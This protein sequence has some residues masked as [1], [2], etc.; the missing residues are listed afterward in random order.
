MQDNMTEH[1]AAN[2]SSAINL[3]FIYHVLFRHKRSIIVFALLGFLAAGVVSYFKRPL[4]YSEAKL[5]VKYVMDARSVS[6]IGAD[7]QMKSPD[8]RGESI[9]NSEIEILNSRDLID[10]V[11]KLL[12]PGK[13]LAKLGGGNNPREAAIEIAKKLNVD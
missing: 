6:T 7:S 8:A 12:G 5:L 13:V 9:I 2:E 1:P 11:V 4:Y 10:S 3:E